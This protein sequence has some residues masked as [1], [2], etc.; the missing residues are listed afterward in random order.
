MGTVHMKLNDGL[1]GNEE[2]LA[3]VLV[4]QYRA[5]LRMLRAVI[6]AVP[7]AL[8]DDEAYEHRTWRLAYHTLYTA[9]MYLAPSPE[10]FTPWE[11]AIDQAN[12]LGGEW[13]GLAGPPPVEGVHTP[14]ELLG[15]LDAIH[16][17]LPDAVAALPLAGGSGFEWY[18]ISRLELHLMSIR[19]VQHHTAQLIER[20]R[21]HG[22]RGIDWA[23][24]E[25]IPGW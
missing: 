8:W 20:L 2:L 14:A 19:H 9:G 3:S 17:T 6:E 10:A 13:E 21:T 7:P 25:N 1:D 12:S 5:G 4:S 16:D 18:P 11:G 22:V 24:G 15:Y 23:P